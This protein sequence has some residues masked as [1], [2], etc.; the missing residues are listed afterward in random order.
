MHV[1]SI[2]LSIWPFLFFFKLIFYLR[3]VVQFVWNH[4]TSHC[5]SFSV[6]HNS[7]LAVASKMQ[8]GEWW[9]EQNSRD[10]FKTDLQDASYLKP[11]VIHLP[12]GS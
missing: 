10:L 11:P 12:L 1:K 2:C 8:A 7:I 3:N 6:F 9:V 5:E 4:K